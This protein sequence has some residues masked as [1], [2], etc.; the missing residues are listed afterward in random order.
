MTFT[1]EFRVYYADTDAYGVVWHGTYLRWL[2]AGRIEYTEKT[3]GLNLKTM[4]EQGCI[5]PIV[6]I[7]VKY[8]SSARI[9]DLLIVETDIEQ[10]RPS[11][12]IFKQTIKNKITGVVH[13]SALVTCV[14]VDT[15]TNKMMRR[16]PDCI[17]NIKLD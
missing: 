1:N 4:Q 2:E 16:L 13:I 10:V 11:A 17:A 15:T 6:D 8:K 7:S 9:D 5:L 14:A 3:F 12:I